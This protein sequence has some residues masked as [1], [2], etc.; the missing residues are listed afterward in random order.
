M[1][2]YPRRYEEWIELKN[3]RKV[4]LRPVKETDGPLLVDLFNKMSP[5]SVHLRFLSPLPQLPDQLV[6]RFTHLDYVK[7][8]G[9]AA[10]INEDSGPIIGVARYA[11]DPETGMPELAIAVRDD[12]Q[13][14]GLGT[15][16]LT[17]VINVGKENGYSRFS[18]LVDPQN[19]TMMHLFKRS[20]Y[21]TEVIRMEQGAYF[22]E[23][24]T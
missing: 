17:R 13:G 8:F 10:L 20:G 7:E 19:R 24:Q 4:F 2:S 22:L 18:A 6:Y 12:W 5:S 9:L 11:Y 23:I 15:I 14:N 3:G 21:G 16:F 1:E